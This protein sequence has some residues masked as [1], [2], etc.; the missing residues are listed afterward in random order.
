VELAQ[1]QIFREVAEAGSINAAAQR[2]HRVPSNLTTRLKQ[3]ESELGADLFIREKMRLRLSATGR[4]FLDYA[5]RIL[6]LAEEARL[7]I[8][9]TEP[10]GALVIGALESTA[11]V[12]I[13]AVLAAFH[14]RYP[15]VELDLSTGPSGDLLGRVL[16]GEL[17]G[18]FVDGPVPHPDLEG[19]PVFREEM[20]LVS[21]LRHP[22][23][24]RAQDVNSANIYAFRSNCAYRRMFEKWFE[25]DAAAPGKI[26][27]LESYHGMLACVSAGAGLAL[28]PASMLASM[29]SRRSVKSHKLRTMIG[30]VAIYLVWRRGLR[31]PSLMALLEML[32]AS[33]KE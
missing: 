29:P 4:S 20:V 23:I 31:S 16:E 14:R 11:A 5:T 21:A 32:K 7:S 27:E 6:D 2:L 8:A 28:L 10:K 9:G 26:F 18:A 33:A 12:R 22:P 25:D 15:Q 17:A 13:P 24:L 1:L 30:K 19:V 3:L